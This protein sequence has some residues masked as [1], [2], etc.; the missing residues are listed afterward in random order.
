MSLPG[1]EIFRMAALLGA[2]HLLSAS[3]LAQAATNPP[4]SPSPNSTDPH[5]FLTK[6]P[7]PPWPAPPLPSAR[8]PISF[9]HELLAMNPVERIQALTNRT[10]EL[11]S[12]ILAKVREYESLEPD[13]RELRLRVTELRW[14]LRPLMTAPA[15]NRAALLAVIPERDR[16]LVV[17]RLQ[18]WD[19][20]PPDVQKELLGIEPTLRY[21]AEIEGHGNLQQTQI[22]SSISPERRELLEKGIRQWNSLSEGQRRSTLRRFNQFF[23]L[24]AVEKEKALR[25]LSEPERRQIEKTLQ[26]FGNLRPEQRARCINSFAKFASLS[27]EERQQFLKNAERWKLMPPS[28]R[29]AWRQLVSILPPPLPPRLP[30]PPPPPPPPLPPPRPPRAVVTNGN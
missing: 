7:P 6:P 11:R 27:L 2:S 30:P 25:T 8:S 10:P 5:P 20:V 19:K 12:Q 29:Q 9:F 13:E 28:E 18:E 15:T 16:E 24:T 14:Y 21:F 1:R 3:L 4:A 22:L 23:E 17:D 26:T